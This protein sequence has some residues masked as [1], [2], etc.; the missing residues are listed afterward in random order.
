MLTLSA[1]LG[2]VHICTCHMYNIDI[3]CYYILAFQRDTTGYFTSGQ[4]SVAF[5][6]TKP[7]DFNEKQEISNKVF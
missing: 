5:V 7:N 1:N 6:A 3:G 2:Y 4:F